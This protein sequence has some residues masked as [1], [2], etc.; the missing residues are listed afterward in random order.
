MVVEQ[1]VAAS[2]HVWYCRAA[3][4]ESLALD[5]HPLAVGHEHLLSQVGVPDIPQRLAVPKGN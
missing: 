4:E 3:M 2:R 1:E 5:T